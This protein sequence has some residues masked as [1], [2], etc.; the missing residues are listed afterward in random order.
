MLEID[1]VSVHYGKIQALDGIS[2]HVEDGE[3]VAVLGP[4]GAG[5]TS[6]MRAVM[7]LEPT[8]AGMITL[9]AEDVGGME[10]WERARKGMAFIPEGGRLFPNA[11]V[12]QNLRV[13]AY[14]ERDDEVVQERLSDV[15]ELFP[16]LQERQEQLAGTL[17]GGEQQ[18]L[19]IGRAMM[20]DPE[21]ILV[22]EITMGLM[23]TLVDRAFDVLTDLN[24]RD[25]AILQ[26]EQNVHKTLE[27]ADRLYVLENG[28]VSADGT[29]E[30]LSEAAEIEASYLGASQED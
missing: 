19:A 6:L 25:I 29:P 12:R 21:I 5:K 17:S 3:H 23:P 30:E 20:I 10:P 8:S 9:E 22:D 1:D 13:G 2:I 27:V 26:V 18:M 28:R 14:L 15:F 7:G 24:D 16:R 11:S 4:N